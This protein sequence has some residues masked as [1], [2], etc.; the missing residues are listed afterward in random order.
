V[1]LFGIV[2]LASA[3]FAVDSNRCSIDVDTPRL[4]HAKIWREQAFG[5]DLVG[6]PGSFEDD[7]GNGDALAWPWNP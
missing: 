4:A 7:G 1:D 3:A 6:A 5:L 2:P